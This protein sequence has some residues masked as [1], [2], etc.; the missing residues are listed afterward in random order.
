MI[1]IRPMRDGEADKV[2]GMVHR[3]AADIGASVIPRLTGPGLLQ[4][5]DLVD[6]TVAEEAGALLGACLSLMTYSTWRGARGLYV[7]D[8][9][10]VPEARR[11]KVGPSLLR[12]AAER[13]RSRG[14][15]FVKLEVDHA[16]DGAA[17]F[18]QRLGFKRHDEDRLFVLEEEGLR[19]FLA[20]AAIAVT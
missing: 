1:D 4:A 15:R 19:D 13:G 16:N 12:L 3:L 6:V 14:A 5:R 8:L 18:Y 10:V 20:G 7:V 9:F 2:A 11:R 17:R